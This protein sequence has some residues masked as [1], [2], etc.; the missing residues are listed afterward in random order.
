MPKD[1]EAHSAPSAPQSA[2]LSLPS[3]SMMSV[4]EWL[5][6]DEKLLS[7]LPHKQ[8]AKPKQQQ[9]ESVSTSVA[10]NACIQQATGRVTSGLSLTYLGLLL[11]RD[12]S[13]GPLLAGRGLGVRGPLGGHRRLSGP[14]QLLRRLRRAAHSC[15]LLGK[16]RK[17]VI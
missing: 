13:G 5:V 10:S 16:R 4:T 14:V 2:H 15:A 8:P 1:T 12:A 6:S 17:D 11:A 3:W 7:V 9:Q